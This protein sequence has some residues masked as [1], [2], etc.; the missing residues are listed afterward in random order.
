[1]LKFGNF[2]KFFK[3]FACKTLIHNFRL[4]ECMNLIFGGILIQSMVKTC[5]KYWSLNATKRYP[6]KQFKNISFLQKNHFFINFAI[7]TIAGSY[8]TDLV[9]F[10][11]F[12]YIPAPAH[13]PNIKAPPPAHIP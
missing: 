9:V 3:K 12:S 6:F 5:A 10:A 13:I 4:G 2:R 8:P 11:N 7:F 1:M